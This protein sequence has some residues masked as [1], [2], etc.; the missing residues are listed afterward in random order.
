MGRGP[1]TAWCCTADRCDGTT[2]A[3]DGSCSPV[4]SGA[5]PP[6]SAKSG[7]RRPAGSTGP[8]ATAVRVVGVPL[9][10]GSPGSAAVPAAC[11][12]GAYGNSPAM[13]RPGR[14]CS[15]G[16]SR[17]L[18]GSR[19]NAYFERHTRGSSPMTGRPFTTC[20]TMGFWTATADERSTSRGRTRTTSPATR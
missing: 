2:T 5:S 13:V 19:T 9:E 3:N 7:T 10:V 14:P 20:A 12:S 15:Q 6:C 8:F 1:K 4:R 16:R 17:E 11:G 18:S